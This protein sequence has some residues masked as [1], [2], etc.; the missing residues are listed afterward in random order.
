[1]GL[2]LRGRRLVV[3]YPSACRPESVPYHPVHVHMF[4]GDSVGG[5]GDSPAKPPHR[6]KGDAGKI[7]NLMF[8]GQTFAFFE[9]IT[10]LAGDCQKNIATCPVAPH[11]F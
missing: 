5:G 1:M 8:L 6:D 9:A 3:S 10:I 2:A 4:S 11:S 7:Q